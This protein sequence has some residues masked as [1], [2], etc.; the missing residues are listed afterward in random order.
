MAFSMKPITDTARSE[1][2]PLFPD[3][4]R[5][6]GE[7]FLVEQKVEHE[8]RVYAGVPHGMSISRLA[9]CIY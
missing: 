4:V 9:R 3:D 5:S 8:M 1:N 2:D 6:S 7:K